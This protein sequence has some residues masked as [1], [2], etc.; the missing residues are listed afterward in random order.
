MII[1]Q[2]VRSDIGN[3]VGTYLAVVV[4]RPAQASKGYGPGQA[5]ESTWSCG[6]CHRGR[7][8]RPWNRHDGLRDE[9]P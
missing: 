8:K 5:L 2:L 9:G 1:D 7:L 3:E 6:D 4:R